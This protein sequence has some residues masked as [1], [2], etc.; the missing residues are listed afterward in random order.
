M[1]LVIIGGIFI[2]SFGVPLQEAIYEKT[3]VIV[4][5]DER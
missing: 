5:A 3:E 4:A 2:A 1:F